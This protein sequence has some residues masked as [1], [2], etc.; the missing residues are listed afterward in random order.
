MITIDDIIAIKTDEEFESAALELF[1]FQSVYCA[2]YRDYL[3]LAEI[4]IDAVDSVYKIPFLP[5]EIFKEHHVYCG[6]NEPQIIFTSSNT[7]GSKPSCHPMAELSIYEKAF[8]AAFEQ[9]YGS[10]K[11]VSIYGLLPNYLQRQGSSLIYMVDRLIAAGN[12][13]G[14]ADRDHAAA[15]RGGFYLDDYPKLISDMATDPSPKILLGVSYALWDLAEQFAP[16]LENTIVMETGGMKGQREE[17]PKAEFHALLQNAFGVDK[18]HSEYGMAELTSQAYS[19]GNGVFE[20][21]P[22]LRVLTRDINDTFCITGTERG[23]I[24]IIDLGNIYSCAFIQTQDIG[25]A[26]S[27]GRFSIVGRNDHSEIRGCNL[28]VSK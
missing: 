9:F 20:A 11:E 4:D 24:N 19:K 25:V 22:W 6:S 8:F 21:P 2:P 3:R 15:S 7:G 12:D 10:P 23:G 18:I 13:N 14:I 5:I 1:R 28:L 16:K 26:D 27:S 17:L